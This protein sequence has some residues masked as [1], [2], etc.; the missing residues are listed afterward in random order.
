MCEDE[1]YY[2]DYEEDFE[3]DDDPCSAYNCGPQCQYWGG[4]GICLLVKF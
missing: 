2:S 1:E 4:D 3:E